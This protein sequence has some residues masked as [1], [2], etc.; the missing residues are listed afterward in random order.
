MPEDGKPHSAGQCPQYA[1]QYFS[2]ETGFE[3]VLACF[4]RIK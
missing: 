3:F 2:D 1:K 4:G